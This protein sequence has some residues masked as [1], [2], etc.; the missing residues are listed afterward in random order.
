M[1]PVI[2]VDQVA[3]R[4]G[5]RRALADVSLAVAAG[6]VVALIG[7]NGAGKSTLL[8]L[9]A[10]LVP[11]ASGRV[12]RTGL[13]PGDIA[14]LAQSAPLPADFS[15]R[16]L[17]ELGRVPRT[18]LFRS[19]DETDARAV[20]GALTR[21]Q[22]LP[23]SERR[24]RELSGGEQQRLALARALAQEPRLLLLDEPTQHLDLRHQ[25]ALLQTLRAEAARGVAVVVVLHD[26]N[27]AARADRV[28][29]LDR[30]KLCALGSPSEVLR[31]AALSAAYEADI[32]VVDTA[33]GTAVIVKVPSGAEN[34]PRDLETERALQ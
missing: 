23:F 10:G 2:A 15:G 30:G 34:W 4:Y 20:L 17:V 33:H 32:D 16:A 25:A 1:T 31:P 14:Y 29:L 8:K 5:A 26:L 6:E 24:L 11:P 7:P 9:L 3:V 18:G 27:L 28:A 22:S 19:P 13:A 21:T 12:D